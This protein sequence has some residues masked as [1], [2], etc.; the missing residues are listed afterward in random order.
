MRAAG[1]AKLSALLM[2]A[3][4]A[5]AQSYCESKLFYPA[6]QPLSE[7]PVSLYEQKVRC[8]AAYRILHHR[9]R[10][11]TEPNA[12]AALAELQG[13]DERMTREARNLHF[14]CADM[15]ALLLRGPVFLTSDIEGAIS[16]YAHVP[17]DQRG[18]D[19]ILVRDFRHCQETFAPK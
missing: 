7:Q 17:E 12:A 6:M 13:G 2:A 15:N 9:F 18:R 1:I 5:H 8:A 4:A 11:S 14:A 16:K 19:G 3:N 10:D